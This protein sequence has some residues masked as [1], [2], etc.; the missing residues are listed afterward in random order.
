MKVAGLF[1]FSL[2]SVSV[3]LGQTGSGF[4]KIRLGSD[5]VSE[6]V[7]VADVNKDGKKDVLA[8]YYWFE[9]P[10]WTRHEIVPARVFD[11]TKE[12]SNSFVNGAFDVN[13]DGWPDQLIV[14]FPGDPGYWFEN[15]GKKT[16]AWKKHFIYDTLGIGNESPA[17]IDIDGDKRPD[18]LCS[19]V[20][21]KQLIWLKSPTK[22]GDTTWT[23]F[24]I[25]EENAPATDKFSHG[26][27]FGD[28]NGDG[29]KDVI[30]KQGWYES[31]RD[32]KK[33]GWVF[34]PADFGEDCS[35]MQAYDVN[36]DGKTDVVSAS[37][38]R[39]G[40]WWYEQS[41][42][43]GT[44]VFKR[45][46]ISDVVSQTHS[47]SLTDL[48]SDGKPDFITG[49]RYLA[50]H[51][52]KD[53]GTDAPSLL[54][55][56]ESNPDKEPYWIQHIIDNDSGSGLHVVVDDMDKDGKT[57]IIVSNKKGVFIFLNRIKS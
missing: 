20:D 39:L 12:Y 6:G 29:V 26:L 19:D 4:E 16:G 54:I 35:Q 11:P 33:S 22:K 30:I 10:N 14:D 44:P 23:R 41:D 24:S 32:P 37:A 8:G 34:H 53:P 2:I 5:F 36:K 56:F 3:C 1:C 15:P 17:F 45:H 18:L 28:M 46:V 42:S 47:S 13:S 9:A 48:N 55:W 52:A 43:S 7:S 38:H 27:G 51:A 40:I 49:K 57:D 50:H 31:P 25:S 21:K